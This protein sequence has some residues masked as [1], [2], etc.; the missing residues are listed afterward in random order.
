M[1]QTLETS[2]T[3]TPTR[4]RAF[5]APP[6]LISVPNLATSGRSPRPRGRRRRLRREVRLAG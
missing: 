2:N 5:E 6:V 4:P 3:L 1:I